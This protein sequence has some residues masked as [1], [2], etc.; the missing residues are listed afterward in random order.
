MQNNDLF[1]GLQHI[2]K[3]PISTCKAVS[4]E[5]LVSPYAR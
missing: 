4:V 1:T 2:H 5:S 3:K